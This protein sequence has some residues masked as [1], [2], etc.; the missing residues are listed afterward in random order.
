MNLKKLII[1]LGIVTALLKT[2]PN[3]AKTQTLTA[4]DCGRRETTKNN[5]T[6]RFALL[7]GIKEYKHRENPPI[8]GAETDVRLMKDV[9]VEN[10]DFPDDGRHIKIL[11]TA[12]ATRE[13][14]LEEFRNFL[15]ANAAA[16]NSKNPIIV[17]Y[18][19][20]HGTQ[21]ENQP[22]DK[23]DGDAL[24]GLDEA[25]VPYDSRDRGVFD[26][27]DDELDD[28]SAELAE[29]SS[30]I[31]F[32]FDSCHSGTVSRGKLARETKPN[33]RNAARKPYVRKFSPTD[34]DE[35]RRTKIVTLAAALPHQSAYPKMDLSGGL[36][37]FHLVAA[38]RRASRQTTY[39]ELMREV[40]SGVRSE[41]NDQHPFADGDEMRTV[42]GEASNRRDAS[43]PILTETENGAIKFGAGRIHGVQVGSQAAIYDRCAAKYTGDEGFLTYAVVSEV[44]DRESIAVL[45][46][47]QTNPKVRAVKKDSRLV[48]TAPTFGGNPV[49]LLLDDATLSTKNVGAE[50]AD[51][52]AAIRRLLDAPDNE[53]KRNRLIELVERNDARSSPKTAEPGAMLVLRRGKFGAVFP[54]AS[55]VRLPEIC[56]AAGAM[57]PP[58]ET[59]IYYLQSA[60]AQR[61]EKIAPL[62]GRFFSAENP[63]AAAEEIVKSIGVYTRQR[64]LIN[65]ENKSSTL[66][67]RIELTLNAYPLAVIPSCPIAGKKT[68]DLKTDRCDCA[69]GKSAVIGENNKIPQNAAF[70]IE[71]KNVS[72]PTLAGKLYIAALLVS[73]DGKIRLESPKDAAK[74]ELT[75]EKPLKITFVATQPAG[76]EMLKVIVTAKPEDLEGIAWL[77]TADAKQRNGVNSP[78]AQLL[79]QSGAKS[80]GASLIPDSPNSWGVKAIEWTVGD[81]KFTC[82]CNGKKPND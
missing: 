25:I 58:P 31:L 7:V 43:I 81:A 59:E 11:K 62:F 8:P 49:S 67:D 54:D 57:F 71:I 42:L 63:T 26:I 38:L 17:F 69:D 24:D 12:E 22:E 78:L 60:T 36:M 75:K 82:A 21:Y 4:D 33:P 53:L 2:A 56:R 6:P 34:A 72:R 18:F 79:S 37:T 41:N 66:N 55:R 28:L 61:D 3:S 1:L 13:R 45:P 15:V 35:A 27:L 23:S 47:A 5:D 50:A 77:E 14:I 65:L 32:V 51:V 73:A 16:N 68:L 19:S 30:N 9:L 29:Y 44:G 20:G 48:L 10:Y 74:T 80:R 46:D 76:A 70:Q 52:R 64:N 40:R 39:Q